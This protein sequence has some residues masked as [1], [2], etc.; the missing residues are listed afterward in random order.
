MLD[1]KVCS[2]CVGDLTHCTYC[3]ECGSFY[4]HF[5][6]TAISNARIEVMLTLGFII[7]FNFTYWLKSHIFLVLANMS[8]FEINNICFVW[9]LYSLLI[10]VIIIFI[11]IDIYIGK[12]LYE[13]YYLCYLVSCVQILYLL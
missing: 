6:L 9:T 10:L 12:Q 8:F 7:F 3:S 11:Y 5:S 13:I 4:M 1:A 2:H